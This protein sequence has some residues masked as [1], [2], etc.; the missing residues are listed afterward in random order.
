MN[1]R[2]RTLTLLALVGMHLVMLFPGVFAPYDFTEQHRDFP[3]V[4]PTRLHLV[5]ATG[6]VHL[7]PFVYTLQPSEDGSAAYVEDRSHRY[8]IRLFVNGQPYRVLGLWTA[9]AH[10]F[11]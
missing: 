6:R 8:G 2:W 11:G 9:R 1:A 3:F 5:D 7:W 4:S 10:L